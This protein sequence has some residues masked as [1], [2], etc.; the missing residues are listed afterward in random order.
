MVSDWR[1]FLARLREGIDYCRLGNM[2]VFTPKGVAKLLNVKPISV[3]TMLRR[4]QIRPPKL[5]G[6]LLL[7]ED[8]IQ[9]LTE[10]RR[11]VGRPRKT[12]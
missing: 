12:G 9:A 8:I 10:K 1:N 11:P 3:R 7:T 2:Y 4:H 6:R 5:D